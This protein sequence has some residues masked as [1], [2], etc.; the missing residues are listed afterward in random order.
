MSYTDMLAAFGIGSAHPG[1]FSKSKQMLME[2]DI[3]EH[4][5]LLDCGCGTGQTAAYIKQLF[6]CQ[7]TALEPHPIMAAKAKKR[8]KDDW[9]DIRLLNKS[10]ESTGLPANQFDYVI[11]ESVLSFVPLELALTEIHRLL[12]PNGVLFANELS[13]IKLLTDVERNQIMSHYSFHTLNSYSD[14][15]KELLL[16]GF[17]HSSMLEEVSAAE[18]QQDESDKGNDMIPSTGIPTHRFDQ[19]SA[20]AKMMQLYGDRIGHTL[21]KAT[22]STKKE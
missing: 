10:I 6:D 5:T 11:C 3:D 13:C 16:S 8:F 7:I 14:W 20:H 12:K 4:T 15:E 22:A 18:L 19:V 9:L 17:A 1:G 2:M 21:F